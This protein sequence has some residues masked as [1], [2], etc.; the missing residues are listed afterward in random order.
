MRRIIRRKNDKK[1]MKILV[2]RSLEKLQN[3]DPK[4]KTTLEE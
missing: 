1:Y 4:N 2:E 3:N